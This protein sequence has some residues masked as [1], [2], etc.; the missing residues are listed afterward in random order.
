VRQ[1][2]TFDFVSPGRKA[3]NPLRPAVSAE[4]IGAVSGLNRMVQGAAIRVSDYLDKV[5]VITF[6]GAV[7]RGVPHRGAPIGEG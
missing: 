1:G 6:C 5:V 4:A 2:G 3:G 7:M